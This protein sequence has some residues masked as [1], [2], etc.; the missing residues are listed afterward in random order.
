MDSHTTQAV[1]KRVELFDSHYVTRKVEIMLVVAK[2]TSV[3]LKTIFLEARIS[4]PT[5]ASEVMSNDHSR[6]FIRMS[7]LV[8]SR[9]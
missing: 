5:H 4:W 8:I 3:L 6:S 2:M 7:G 1:C 9:D